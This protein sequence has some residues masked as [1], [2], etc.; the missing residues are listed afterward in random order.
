VYETPADFTSGTLQRRR[1]DWQCAPRVYNHGAKGGDVGG[2]HESHWTYTLETAFHEYVL[3]SAHRTTDPNEAEYFYAPFFS[4][5]LH[6]RYNSPTAR[7]WPGMNP[8]EDKTR[9]MGIWYAWWGCSS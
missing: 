7:H 8:G 3:R 1:N 2:Q 6:I 9:P 5:C 4:A